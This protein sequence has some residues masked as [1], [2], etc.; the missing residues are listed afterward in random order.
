MFV[1]ERADCDI[2]IQSNTPSALKRNK[3]LIHVTTRLCLE[4][5]M[6]HD[7]RSRV[8]DLIHVKFSGGQN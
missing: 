6:T 8:Y 3:L 5:I 1:S 2:A 7:R 4:N